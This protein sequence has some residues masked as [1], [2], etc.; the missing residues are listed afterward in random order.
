MCHLSQYPHSVAVEKFQQFCRAYGFP[1]RKAKAIS[2][3][4]FHLGIQFKGL[5]ES[6]WTRQKFCTLLGLPK[7]RGY[8]FERIG[9]PFKTAYNKQK[10]LSSVEF[11]KWLE[12]ND[13]KAK[14]FPYIENCDL[15]GCEF[16]LG[17][18]LFETYLDW[19]EYGLI[20][21]IPN[22]PKPLKVNSVRYPSVS[23][24]AK[25]VF[26]SEHSLRMAANGVSKNCC[27][28]EVEWA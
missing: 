14:F 23:A 25:A 17:K 6:H 27:I 5:E 18:K 12:S 21:P 7:H 9:V 11:R 26:V 8:C 16:V 1:K 3:K 10:R 2:S 4:F 19:D 15:D 28:K 24:A 20:K 13:N 22:R